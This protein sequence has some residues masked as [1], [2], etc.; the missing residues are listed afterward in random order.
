MHYQ[1]STNQPLIRPNHL[2]VNNSFLPYCF[3]YVCCLN[4]YSYI[5]HRPYPIL[6]LRVNEHRRA[7][8]DVRRSPARNIN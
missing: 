8:D 3:T 4:H 5:Q 6:L 2:I 7:H 1:A